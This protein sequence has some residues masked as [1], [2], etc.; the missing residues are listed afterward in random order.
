MEINA[1]SSATTLATT[2]TKTSSGQN[3]KTSEESSFKNEMDKV[4]GTDKKEK[5]SNVEK[6]DTK[7]VKDE[8]PLYKKALEE[9]EDEE[10]PKEAGKEPLTK[11]N[12]A[13][14]SFSSSEQ[15]LISRSPPWN[16]CR[17]PKYASRMPKTCS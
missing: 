12:T 10:V 4:N 13:Q 14:P 6:K 9:T 1:T 2:A 16:F 11:E 8:D 3:T 15:S 5:E 17:S 7:E